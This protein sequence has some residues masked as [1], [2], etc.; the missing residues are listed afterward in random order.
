MILI[1]DEKMESGVR[2]MALVTCDLIK[3]EF[4]FWKTVEFEFNHPCQLF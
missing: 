2:Y 3:F 1:F 4:N